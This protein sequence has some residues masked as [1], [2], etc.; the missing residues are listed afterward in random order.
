MTRALRSPR[1]LIS[2]V[3]ALVV[4]LVWLFAFF[5]PQGKKLNTLNTQ[6]MQ[7]QVK[8]AALQAQLAALERT[9][10]AT[11]QLLALQ[12]QFAVAVPPLPNT[13]TYISTMVATT[14][15]AGTKLVS[16][17]TGSPGAPVSGISPIQVSLSTT[18]T[19][20]QTLTL[21]HLLNTL[22]RLT[23]INAVNL[24]GGGPNTTRST[25]LNESFSLTI[26]T[27]NGSK[28]TTATPAT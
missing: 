24:L 11:P 26:F 10:V 19:Y 1:V 17:T 14:K 15:A 2:L 18:G 4:V 12:A 5:L 27:S 22:P 6:E 13:Y 7:L 20:D 28:P 23:I 25:T 21:I 3:V 8:Q 9:A 16:I